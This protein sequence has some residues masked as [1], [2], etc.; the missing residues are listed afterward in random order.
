MTHQTL[1]NRTPFLPGDSVYISMIRG[2]SFGERE[3]Q[4][5]TNCYQDLS[6]L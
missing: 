1:P 6:V 3:H 5:L 2:A 4:L